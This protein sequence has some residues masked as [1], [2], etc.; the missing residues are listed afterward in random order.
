MSK[1]NQNFSLFRGES[2]SIFV[3]LDAVEGEPF[4]PPENTMIEWWVGRSAA[5]LGDDKGVVIKKSLGSGITLIGGGVS[6]MLAAEDSADLPP[7]FYAHQMVVVLPNG[8][9]SVAMTGTFVLR[10]SMDMRS[11]PQL[12]AGMASAHGSGH[13]S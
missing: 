11:H 13:V 2:R 4:N 1:T 10:G 7:G 6:I 3:E 5:T 8:G 12:D 9:V